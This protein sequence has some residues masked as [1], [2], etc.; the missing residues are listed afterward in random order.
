MIFVLERMV[1]IAAKKLGLDPVEIRLRNFV[2][3]QQMPYTTPSGEIY[4]SGDYPQ[5]LKK[6]L[7]LIGY[8]ELKG[9]REEGR[10]KVEREYDQD[11]VFELLRKEYERLL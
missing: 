7:D 3:P 4:E 10:K 9:H 8:E 6:A 11:A 5:C 2:Q 1:G